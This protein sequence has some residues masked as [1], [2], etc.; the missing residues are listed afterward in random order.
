M[1]ES[2]Y[3]YT[4]PEFGMRDEAVEKVKASLRKKFPNMDERLYFLIDTPLSQ[5]MTELQNGTLF[6]DATCVVC[7]NAELLKKKEDIEAINEWIK[8]CDD[9]SI[10]I[11]VSDEISVDSKLDKLVP[12]ANKKKFWEMFDNQKLPWLVD[13]FKKN[14]YSIYDDA[15][16]LILEMIENNTMALKNEC[17]RFF[18]CFPKDHIITADDVN[19][20]L[21]H[22]RDENAFTLFNS[23]SQYKIPAEKRLENGISILQKIRLSKEK[24]SVALI[25]GLSSCFRKLITWH[26]LCPNDKYVD[27]FTLKTNGFSSKLMQTQYRNAA[28]IWTFGQATAILALLSNTD[29]NIRSGGTL[30]EDIYLEKLLYEIVIKKGSSLETADYC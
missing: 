4:G 20:V 12:T 30:L 1:P 23:I 26:K 17:S 16:E 11:L 7:K 8:S 19:S 6:S 27:E 29:M 5:I 3:L 25:A 14:G 24:S 15:A 9:T 22:N 13:Y 21:T 10:L 18:I 28:K 2:I